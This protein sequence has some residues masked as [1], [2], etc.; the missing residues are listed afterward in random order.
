M[1]VPLNGSLYVITEV[2]EAVPAVTRCLLEPLLDVSQ[3]EELLHVLF[4]KPN[5]N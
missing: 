4:H 1:S 5:Y 3:Q 2:P